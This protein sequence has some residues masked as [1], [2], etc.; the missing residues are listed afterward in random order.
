[1]VAGLLGAIDALCA[2]TGFTR[3]GWTREG[4]EHAAVCARASL[5]ATE[6]REAWEHGYHLESAQV[7]ATAR[8]FDLTVP[9]RPLPTVAPVSAPRA[10]AMVELTP[11]EREILGLLC[12]RQTN[13]EIAEALF[14][15][16]RT[17]ES[18]V[19]NILGKLGVENRREAAAIAARLKL[20]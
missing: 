15:S 8:S 20:V 19:R 2:Q 11:R 16:I 7:V 1:V 10:I 17:V 6:F 18:H 12:A 5:G 9:P 3:Y 4:Y 14:L 13:P